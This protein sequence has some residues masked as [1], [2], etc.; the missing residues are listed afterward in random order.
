MNK[1]EAPITI[2]INRSGICNLR[3]PGCWGPRHSIDIS[4]GLDKWSFISE[5]FRSRGTEAVVVTGG[6]PLIHPD[7]K[8][9]INMLH[10]MQYHITLS[11]NGM[12]LDE[13][14][15]VLPSINEIGIPLDG[16]NAVL[17]ART[18]RPGYKHF[19]SAID[20]MKIVKKHPNNVHLTTR[21]WVNRSNMDDIFNIGNLL[22][23]NP[24]F[25]PDRWKL[26]QY[27]ATGGYG[28]ASADKLSISN[29]E[30]IQLLRD[31]SSEFPSLHVTGLSN[32]QRSGRY[33][34]IMPNADVSTVQKDGITYKHL[35]NALTDFENVI[36]NFLAI[37][38]SESHLTHGLFSNIK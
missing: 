12:F 21:T 29:Q 17:N 13:L 16:S 27:A 2:D 10:Q 37:T 7:T 23:N 5:Q 31:L 33:V 25:T 15:K 35:G 24:D 9:F 26:Y 34:F 14:E 3:C 19:S 28:E 20:A 8:D 18:R 36:Q 11:T 38:V 6:E 1:L 32:S 22:V 4:L 30:Y